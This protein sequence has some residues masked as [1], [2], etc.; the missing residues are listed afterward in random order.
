MHHRNSYNIELAHI[1]V[2]EDPTEE[3]DKAII[4]AAQRVESIGIDPSLVTT[5][6]LIDDYNPAEKILDTRYFLSYL[7]KK[8]LV[9]DYYV[10]EARLPEFKDQLLGEM[11]GR[12]Q[13]QY[14]EYIK[15]TGKCP[16]S[17]LIA[18]WYLVRL[19]YFS[20]DGIVNSVSGEG[21]PFVAENIINILP[22]RY[23]GVEK[24]GLEILK[25][26]RFFPD[27]S[28]QIEYFFF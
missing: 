25:S 8:G 15:K 23:V 10:Y 22:H 17:F 12:L 20:H 5:S 9:P 7:E 2:N 19:G 14:T 16:C 26:T 21:K 24:K 6:I 27:I 4:L 28:T 13:R 18:V 1:Y 11:T 3:H